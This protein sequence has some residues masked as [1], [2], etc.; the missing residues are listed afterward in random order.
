MK[1][2][3]KKEDSEIT[4][5]NL[6]YLVGNSANN[7]KI[8][9]ILYKEQKGFCSYTEEFIGRT[10]AKDIEHFN[11]TLKGTDEDSYNNWFLVKHQWNKEKASKWEKFQPILHPTDATF[12]NRILFLKGDYVLADQTTKVWD[13]TANSTY[14]NDV[15]G[16]GRDDAMDFAQYQSKSVGVSSDAM[17]TIGL[18]T[19]ADSN[20]NN[21]NFAT[22]FDSNKDFLMWGNDDGSVL[23]GDVTETELI[24]A[25]EKTLA[26][27]WKIVEN[28]SVGSVEIT[29]TKSVLDLALNTAFTVKVL[30]V[31]DDAAFT[32]NVKYA[33]LKED[34]TV[35][36]TEFDFNGTKYF[37]FSEINGIFWNGGATLE[38]DRWLGG[39]NSGKP[40]INAADKD[41]VMVI[42]AQGTSNHPTLTEDAIVECVGLKADSKL[43][44]ADNK[45]V[46]CDEDFIVETIETLE[47]LTEV[48]SLKDEE[49]D[50]V[51]ELISNMYGALEVHKMIKDGISKKEALN[52]FMKRVLGSI[53]S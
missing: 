51:G 36:T 4:E 23:I 52:L 6:S 27:T 50:V 17:I 33:P 24:C 30:K 31:A 28:G 53:D 10:D 13:Y 35:Y 5:Q 16:I 41:K 18:T 3:I 43:M 38:A 9:V 2:I 15:A 25:P 45:Y 42:D 21:V 8:S 22:G 46:E 19:I 14:H 12:E 49:L 29:A 1:R 48:P 20:V 26:R 32:T 11:P 39:D 47:N 37:T 40:T 34:G 44:V 7:K